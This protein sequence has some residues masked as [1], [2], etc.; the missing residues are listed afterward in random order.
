MNIKRVLGLILSLSG[1]IFL[2]VSINGITGF[3]ISNNIIESQNITTI[4]LILVIIGLIIFEL[5]FKKFR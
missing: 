3:A 2:L 5:S 1:I 4:G